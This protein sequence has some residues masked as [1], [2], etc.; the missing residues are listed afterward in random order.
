MKFVYLITNHSSLF[1]FFLF[2][3][4]STESEQSGDNDVFVT[5]N[6]GNLRGFKTKFLNG[7]EVVDFGEGGEEET[8][9]RA[10]NIFRGIPFARPPVRFEV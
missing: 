6:Y 1:V 3:F 10:V 7:E 2:T 8:H 9:H 4:L 5:T